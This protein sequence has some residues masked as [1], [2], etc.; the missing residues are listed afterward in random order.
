[1][2]LAIGDLSAVFASFNV[3]F[4]M[5]FGIN[6]RMKTLL[7]FLLIASGLACASE[8]EGAK[9]LKILHLSFHKGCL[10]EFS[11]IA[12]Q[13]E[14]DVESWF[15]PDLPAKLFDVTSRGNAL[16]NITHERAERIWNRHKKLFE[17]FDAILVSDTAPLSRI[18]LQNGWKKPL[19]IWVCNRFDYCD[20]ASLDGDF[21]DQ[22]YYEL[23]KQAIQ[24]K[25]VFVIPY[26]AFE[27]YYAKSKHIQINNF[28]ITPC[29]PQIGRP[30]DSSIP[31]DVIKEECFFLPP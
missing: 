3:G 8:R 21:P 15:I 29:Y 20:H 25:N 30:Q 9:K 7:L 1:M 23:F 10:H 31:A 5:S 19:I 14:C 4:F 12:K 27:K 18:F 16:Y 22:E 2:P 26:T 6:M 28:V 24:R 11:G 13:L 17:S